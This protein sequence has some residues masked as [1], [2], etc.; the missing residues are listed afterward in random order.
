MADAMITAH[1]SASLTARL[2][3]DAGNISGAK[4]CHI[5]EKLHILQRLG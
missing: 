5:S 4:R 2:P 3:S 1:F